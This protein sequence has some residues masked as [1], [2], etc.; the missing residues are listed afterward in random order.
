MDWDADDLKLADIFMPYASKKISEYH[1]TGKRFVH[2]TSAEAAASIIQ[3][4][5]VWMRKSNL[6]N[7]FMEIEHGMECLR[8]AYSDDKEHSFKNVIDGIFPKFQ[9]K[10]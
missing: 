3:T 10:L 7:D 9:R 8:E 4:E 5:K 1:T 6:M 2:Y